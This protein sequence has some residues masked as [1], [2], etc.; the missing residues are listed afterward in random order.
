MLICCKNQKKINDVKRKLS[1]RFNMKDL[2]KA[3]N[4]ISINIDY[5]TEKNSMNLSQG[6]YIEFL[7]KKYNLGNAK[8]YGIPIEVNLKLEP[9]NETDVRIKYRN[10]IGKLLYIQVMERDLI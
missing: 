4:Y 8:F 3:K 2:G 6:K 1:N 5:D 10:L 9:T 7:A